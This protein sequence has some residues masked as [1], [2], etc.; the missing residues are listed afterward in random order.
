MVTS[1]LTHGVG[2]R[3]D[4]PLPWQFAL[5]GAG[6]ALVV[7]FAVLGFAW[8][9]PK[10]QLA[11]L[12]ADT[13]GQWLPSSGGHQ[14]A[15]IRLW[16]ALAAA[17]LVIY[18]LVV[19]GLIAG[20]DELQNPVFG[21]L[22]V[23][24][25]VGLVPA[26]FCL[27]PLVTALSPHRA[28]HAGVCRL[29]GRD[30]NAGRPLP[31]SLGIWPA[32]VYVTAFVWME[33]VW[34]DRTTLDTMRVWF[35]L[36]AVTHFGGAIIFGS[37]WFAAIDPFENYARL[38]AAISPLAFR[39]KK[40]VFGNPLKHLSTLPYRPGLI[41]FVC[42]ILG[43]TA[44]DSLAGSLWWIGIVQTS[45][46]PGI[47]LNSA[48]LAASIALVVVT[49]YLSARWTIG[50]NIAP[51]ERPKQLLASLVPIVIGYAIAHYLTLF[52]I[53]GQRAVI[54]LS[55]PTVQGLNL[56]GTGNLTL[57]TTIMN[58]VTAIATAQLLAVIIGHVI[59]VV[60]AHDRCVRIL[61]Q[62]AIWTGQMA[63]LIVMVGYTVGGLSLM[64]ID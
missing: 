46:I 40:L 45:S 43:S 61:P 54:Q 55:D 36:Q 51:A 59:A 58:E 64:F 10:H 34:P 27:G 37:R 56:L 31:A 11:P 21:Y 30:P 16:W 20:P 42:V 24:V 15:V 57:D 12:A 2:G 53:E 29:I 4:L 5:C 44:F 63:M 22:Y 52:V 8:R 1:L 7:S 9:T 32:V 19:A 23:L 6:L 62:R 17:S 41:A 33:L 3:Q 26:G 13:D 35:A 38:V 25:W 60:C 39:E 14:P 28:L 18:S 50:A 47:T 48:A 49:F